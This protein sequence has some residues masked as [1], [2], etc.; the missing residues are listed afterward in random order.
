MI[1]LDLCKTIV[2]LHYFIKK[3]SPVCIL[4]YFKNVKM[5]ETII[6]FFPSICVRVGGTSNQ[7]T[8]IVIQPHFAINT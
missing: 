4:F 3:T 6:F 7:K 8:M 5:P 1:W 2:C